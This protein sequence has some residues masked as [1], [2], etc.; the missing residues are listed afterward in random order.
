MR[1]GCIIGL[2]G[3]RGGLIRWFEYA[4]ESEDPPES[5]RGLI[6]G[7][8]RLEV[9]DRKQQCTAFAGILQGV[10]DLGRIAEG[11][12]RVVERPVD[13]RETYTAFQYAS[14]T[15]SSNY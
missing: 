10:K 1:R 6:E 12:K 2:G 4:W 15:V 13:P 9:R 14:H 5:R 8:V 7:I 11:I 3:G